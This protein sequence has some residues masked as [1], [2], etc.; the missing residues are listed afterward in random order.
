MVSQEGEKEFKPRDSL[1]L[2]CTHHPRCWDQNQPAP[3]EEQGAGLGSSTWKWP[4]PQRG[5][6]ARV[7]KRVKKRDCGL[8]RTRGFRLVMTEGNKSGRFKGDSDCSG[9][10]GLQLKPPKSENWGFREKVVVFF[11]PVGCSSC[12]CLHKLYP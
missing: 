3:R 6:T 10:V 1:S 12:G 4:F 8:S 7:I 11:S 2:L 9:F 5:G